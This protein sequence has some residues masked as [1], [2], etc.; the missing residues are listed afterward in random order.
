MKM[1]VLENIKIFKKKIS[2]I[3]ESLC[4]REIGEIN[5]RLL[6]VPGQI[7]GTSGMEKARKKKRVFGKV[8]GI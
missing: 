1:Q 6:G 5:K 4:H 7:L 3:Q 2:K 8:S